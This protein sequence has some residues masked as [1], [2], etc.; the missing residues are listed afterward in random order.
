M[1][2]KPH[3]LSFTVALAL[4]LL[5]ALS[6]GQPKELLAQRVKPA[7]TAKGSKPGATSH[8]PRT[9]KAQ[10]KARQ[11]SAKQRAP[12]RTKI[13]GALKA[14]LGKG[15][16]GQTTRFA[17]KKTKKQSRAEAKEARA[18]A[19]HAKA[20]A[21]AQAKAKKYEA[22]NPSAAQRQAKREAKTKEKD[23]SRIIPKTKQPIHKKLKDPNFFGEKNP[24]KDN[25]SA[26]SLMGGGDTLKQLKEPSDLFFSGDVGRLMAARLIN[27]SG[28]NDADFRYAYGQKAFKNFA[29]ADAVLN[30]IPKGEFA[31]RLDVALLTKLNKISFA[32]GGDTL[33]SKIGKGLRNI[34]VP[35]AKTKAGDLRNY[36][37]YHFESKG[38]TPTEAKNIAEN[39]ARYVKLPFLNKGFIVYANPATVK[40]GLDSLLKETRTQLKDPSSDPI[41][42]ASRFV[43]RFIAL[44]PYADGNGRT[45]R[46]VMD[47]ILAER[48]MLPPILKNTGNDIGL[49]EAN[50]AKEVL[51]GVD[52]TSTHFRSRGL[53][54]M[55]G[56]VDRTMTQQ[57][58]TIAG[59]GSQKLAKFDGLSYGLR[60]DGFVYNSAGRPHMADKNGDLRPLSQMTLYIM[61]RRVSLQKNAPDILQQITGPTRLAFDKLSN[62]KGTGPKV[63]SDTGAIKSDGRLSVNVDGINNS[64]LISLLNPKNISSKNLFPVQPGA[65]ALTTIMSR[66]QQADLELWY[67]KEAFSAKGDKASVAKIEKHRDVLFDRSRSELRSHVKKGSKGDDDNPLGAR[68]EFERIQHQY[69]ALRYAK[70]S[71]YTKKHGDSDAYIFRGENF[72]KWTGV[73]IDARPFRPG[74]KDAAGMRAKS[75]GALNLFDALKA[76][77]GDSVGTGV[78]SYTTDLALLARKDGFADKHRDMKMNLAGMPA[79]GKAIV[80][81]RIKDGESIEVSKSTG[82]LAALFS[83]R[84]VTRVGH[85]SMKDIAKSD[86]SSV[87]K[88]NA[89]AD[90]VDA[91]TKRIGE[92]QANVGKRGLFGKVVGIFGGRRLEVKAD[93][94]LDAGQ[95][96]S[97]NAALGRTRNLVTAHRDGD[98]INVTAHRR[99]NVFKVQKKHMLPGIDSLGGSFVNEQEVHVM[100]SVLPHRILGTFTQK[101]LSTALGPEAKAEAAAAAKPATITKPATIVQATNPGMT[102]TPLGSP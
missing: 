80:S 23:A 56:F 48:G 2:R 7:K 42:T 10:A 70:R 9:K 45:A 5:F 81:M 36:Q 60:K 8:A 66:Y 94:I 67:V 93:D 13:K 14:A 63:L 77:E 62:A 91:L 11:R 101:E 51:R 100:A 35:G 27:R 4:A 44:H 28:R 38:L 24:A 18:L 87:V 57:G 72:A 82:V 40:R 33:A 20:L 22:K 54:N 6:L 69:S 39:G 79:W 78:Q 99:A 71:D 49:S 41:K 32:E 12:I 98:A 19:K 47:R 34:F 15:K 68:H 76:V 3:R 50:F 84:T 26:E 53:E 17:A 96:K 61:M 92:A 85:F 65:S 90:K 89:P 52:R 64:M 43:Q 75:L 29:K 58:H 31:N 16:S 73:H 55:A 86:L 25:I 59:I 21:K 88:E 1:R 30:K 102:V 95:L 83:R 46:L 37:N 97:F 74:L